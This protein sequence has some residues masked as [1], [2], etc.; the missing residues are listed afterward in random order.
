[1]AMA[2]DCCVLD[3]AT[4]PLPRSR[5]LSAGIAAAGSK[6]ADTAS[7]AAVE[8]HAEESIGLLLGFGLRGGSAPTDK[9]MKSARE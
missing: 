9:S 6:K 4:E 2:E 1:M 8:W 3:S 5:S 7:S